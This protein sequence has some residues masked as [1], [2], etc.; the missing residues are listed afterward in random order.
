MF[1]KEDC[2]WNGTKREEHRETSP[3]AFNLWSLCTLVKGKGHYQPL[4]R[5]LITLKE[6]KI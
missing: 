3:E 2:R 4:F 6:N 1:T 5:K